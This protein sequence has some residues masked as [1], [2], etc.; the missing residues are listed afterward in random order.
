V[1]LDVTEVGRSLPA[2]DPRLQHAHEE[3][4]VRIL[5]TALTVLFER[6]QSCVKKEKRSRVL[7][8]CLRTR[9]RPS[10]SRPLPQ[11]L[12]ENGGFIPQLITV[13]KLFEP[14]NERGLGIVVPPLL[15]VGVRILPVQIN[16]S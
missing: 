14:R 15:D 10:F 11:D 1:P 13:L 9:S 2:A 4:T 6:L 5:P 12:L 7:L 16:R 3:N 8:R